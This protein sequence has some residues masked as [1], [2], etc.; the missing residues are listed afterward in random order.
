MFVTVRGI[1][2]LGSDFHFPTCSGFFNIYHP[3]DPVAYRIETLI[4][5]AFDKRP[6]LIPHHKGRKRIHLG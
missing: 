1:E 5:P 2:Q 6:V 4:E 3:Y